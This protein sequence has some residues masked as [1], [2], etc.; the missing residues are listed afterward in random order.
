[1]AAPNDGCAVLSSYSRECNTNTPSFA[2][3]Y[4]EQGISYKHN[5][6]NSGMDNKQPDWKACRSSCRSIVGA[7]FFDWVSPQYWIS[8]FRETC[9]CKY[10]DSGR[11]QQSDTVSG[12]VNCVGEN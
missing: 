12:N 11:Q 1:M 10:S 5:D 7:E 2:E 9:W 3:C 4:D 6:L 8:T